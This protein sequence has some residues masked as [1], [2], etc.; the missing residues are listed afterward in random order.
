MSKQNI[1]LNNG[2]KG[3]QTDTGELIFLIL[4]KNV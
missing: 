2:G 3:I 1:I 4:T